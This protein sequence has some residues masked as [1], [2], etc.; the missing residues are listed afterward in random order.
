[1]NRIERLLD[2]LAPD[3]VLHLPLGDLG[4]FTG[5][6]G[7]QKK[8]LLDSGVPAIHYGQI[9]THYGVSASSTLSFVTEALASRSKR[10]EPGDVLIADTSENDEDLGRAVAWLGAVPAAVSNHTFIFS[11]RL[12][13]PVYLSYYLRSAGFQ[14]QK[15]KLVYGTKV[16]SISRSNMEKVIVPVPPLEVQQEIV[17]ILDKFTELEAE[18]ETRLEAELEARRVQFRFLRAELLADEALNSPYVQIGEIFSMR[19]GE[20]VAAATIAPSEDPEHPF[21]CF[22]G[23][24]IRGYVSEAN[25]NIPAILIGRQGALCGN[26]QRSSGPFFATEHAVVTEPRIE[27]NL[28]WA[29]HKLRQMDLNQY[30]TKSA[31]PGLSVR[32]LSQI[33]L[34]VPPL[35]RQ[36]DIGAMLDAAATLVN[37]ISV[38]LPA[39]RAARRK[40]YEYY[41]DKLLTF[42]EA[43]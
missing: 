13:D 31:Q 4:S 12:V 20:H 23:N 2:K 22:G 6:G 5:G 38:G 7:P 17:G 39:E 21:P 35:E 34:K 26:V 18:L 25:R 10:A 28:S 14:I 24:G 37:D 43:R 40:Q 15:N 36:E 9:Y 3:G 32:K 1:M 30:K 33:P 8:D 16:R 19:A 29:F 42:E 27:L 11:S 41:R